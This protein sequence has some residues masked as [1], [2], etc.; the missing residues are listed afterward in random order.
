[1]EKKIQKK[2]KKDQV[3]NHHQEAIKG[4][5]TRK[6]FLNAVQEEEAEQDILDSGRK[7]GDQ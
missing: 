7:D 2:H 1:M 4:H 3:K 5:R 6:H